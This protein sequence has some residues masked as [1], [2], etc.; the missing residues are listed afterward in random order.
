[1]EIER[2]YWDTACFLAIM[3]NETGRAG[4]CAAI[5]R[6]ATMRR[7]QIV[8]SAL[9]ITEVL[10][11]KGGRPLSPELRAT[12]RRFFKHPGIVLVNVDREV[13]E[14]AQEYYWDH[15]VRPKDAVHVAS[16]VYAGAP[17]FETYDSALIALSGKLGGDPLL[18]VRP[19]EPLPESPSL[20]PQT[21]LLSSE[22]AD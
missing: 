10:F 3:N 18:T 20:P 17:A 11:P 7:L 4:E 15:G 8:T 9:T 5:L 22:D 21:D 13:A 1:M 6:A 12:V 2:R 14:S 16:A 19:P